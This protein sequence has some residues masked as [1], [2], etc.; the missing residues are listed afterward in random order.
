MEVQ[1]LQVP[2]MNSE[3]IVEFST[4]KQNYNYYKVG[5]T[6]ICS[7]A[8]KNLFTSRNEYLGL[9]ENP[10]VYYFIERRKFL[11]KENT[12]V[13]LEEIPEVKLA[14]KHGGSRYARGTNRIGAIQY[15]NELAVVVRHTDNLFP[16]E[17]YEDA[18]YLIDEIKPV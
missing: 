9:P 1:F 5:D 8:R 11:S 6:V 17:D 12:I 4:L 13:Y 7:F 14:K 2:R 15:I 16:N 18:Y 3:Y 10:P